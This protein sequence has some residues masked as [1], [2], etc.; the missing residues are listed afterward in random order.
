[1]T[2]NFKLADK[3][4]LCRRVSIIIESKSSSN[5]IHLI[6]KEITPLF[7]PTSCSEL[8][9]FSF[10][11]LSQKFFHNYIKLFS[12]FERN[13]YGKHWEDPYFP[14]RVCFSHS[15]KSIA[16]K[17]AASFSDSMSLDISC[18][19]A[20]EF[21]CRTQQGAIRRGSQAQA[22]LCCLW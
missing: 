11:L 21:P 8:A 5:V 7:H 4:H 19:Y 17:G 1:M 18:F 14:L 9:S 2:R 15:A 6:D 22:T 12:D 3:M 16:S 13:K 20:F 10:F